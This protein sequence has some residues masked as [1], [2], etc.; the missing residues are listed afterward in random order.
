MEECPLN[1]QITIPQEVLDA[2]VQYVEVS[3]LAVKRALD[4][5]GVHRQAQEKAAALQSGLLDHMIAKGVVPANQKQ[6]AAVMLGAHDTTLNLLKAATDKIAE[7]DT[8]I[9]KLKGNTKVAGDLG[10]GVNAAD[11]NVAGDGQQPGEYNSLTSPMV[12]EKTANLKESDKKLMKLIG[13]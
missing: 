10:E 4:E 13:R 3:S 1:P 5:V 7:Q 2:T 8:V 6:A 11:I 9:K 12:G